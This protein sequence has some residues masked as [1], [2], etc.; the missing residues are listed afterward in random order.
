MVICLN[1]VVGLEEIA[2]SHGINADEKE[3]ENTWRIGG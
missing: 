2:T 3:T 1:S